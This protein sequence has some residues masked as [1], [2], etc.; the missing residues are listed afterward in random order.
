M[1]IL[2]AQLS[3]WCLRAQVSQ[4]LKRR[5]AYNF[6]TN[7]IPFMCLSSKVLKFAQC[8]KWLSV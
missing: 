1:A 5:T 7:Q 6:S 3:K 2:S 8:I 4:V